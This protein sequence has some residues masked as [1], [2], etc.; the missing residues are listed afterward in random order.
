MA[1]MGTRKDR[2]IL[3]SRYPVPGRTKTRLIPFLGAVGAADLQRHLTEKTFREATVA[4]GR[5]GASLEITYEGGTGAEMRRWLG[6]GALYRP[7][8]A[9][10]LGRRMER[11]FRRAFQEGARRAVL[12][13]TDVP[14][15]TATALE[16]ALE[17]LRERDVVLGPSTDGGYWL[18]G[19]KKEA[20]LFREMPWGSGAVL[21]RTLAKAEGLGLCA[22]LLDPLTDVDTPE[23]A[24]AL[25]PDWGSRPYLSVVIPTLNEATH[26]E[27]TVVRALCDEAEV[28]V[29]DGGSGDGTPEAAVRA[30]AR[31]LESPK[32]RGVQQNRGA[33]AARGKVL[34]FLH[35]DT[36]LPEGYINPIFEAFLS[37]D[38]VLGAFR[39]KTDLREPAARIIETLVNFRTGRLRLPYGDQGLFVR[40]E[41][42]QRAGGFP[43]V[44]IAEDLFL[45][46]QLLRQGR[47]GLAKASVTTSGRRWR[48]TGLLRTTW[49]NQVVLAGLALGIS[50]QTLASIYHRKRA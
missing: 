37:R 46:K 45:V 31:L 40:K 39:F 47:L 14:G 4:A 7:Q 22:A 23:D 13:G 24:Q 1:S 5:S 11:A 26:I 38:A 34:V 48:R 27:K 21:S 17:R 44:P 43:D 32:G 29:V 30:G 36:L 20:D 10:D 33:A 50:P 2:L 49:I 16:Q 6:P 8:S 19:L 15:L 25:L 9:G 42:F 41:V 18:I 35:A 12:F 28:I 3:F